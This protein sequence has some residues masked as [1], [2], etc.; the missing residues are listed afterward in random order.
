MNARA[1]LFGELPAA[2]TDDETRAFAW[3][4]INDWFGALNYAHNEAAHSEILD[5]LGWPGMPEFV[6]DAS[7]HSQD[8]P[9]DYGFFAAGVRHQ[10]RLTKRSGL[11]VPTGKQRKRWRAGDASGDLFGDDGSGDRNGPQKGGA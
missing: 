1:D 2:Y 7:L 8:Q 9:I 3:G 6:C 5:S 10:A 11:V 4:L